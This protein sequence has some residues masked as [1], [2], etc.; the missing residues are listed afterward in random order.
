MQ[1][2]AVY[3]QKNL[4]TAVGKISVVDEAYKVI[5]V[6][7]VVVAYFNGLIEKYAASSLWSTF[8]MLKSTIF[9]FEKID[10]S[11]YVSWFVNNLLIVIFVDVY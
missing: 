8:S 9:V 5:N 7:V 3:C 4:K 2:H 6:N 1:P 10:M 11:K